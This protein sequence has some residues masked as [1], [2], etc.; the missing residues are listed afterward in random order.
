M[1]AQLDYAKRPPVARRRWFRRAVG[2]VMIAGVALS[3]A[4]WSPTALWHVRVLFVQR[5]CLGFTAKEGQLVCSEPLPYG[6]QTPPFT[7]AAP[8]PG[9]LSALVGLAW[10]SRPPIRMSWFAEGPVLFLH[11]RRSK[12][13]VRRM[14]VVRRTPPN[15]RMSWDI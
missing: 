10:G 13:G 3:A 7:V 1:T 11:E 8:D 15:R 9:C 4:W 12:G 6:G 5:Q 14:V 2:G